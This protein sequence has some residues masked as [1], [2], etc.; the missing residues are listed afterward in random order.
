VSLG[1]AELLARLER[2]LAF[3]LRHGLDHEHGGFLTSLDHDGFVVDDDKSVWM[4]GRAAW[5]FAHAA[6]THQDRAEWR[7]AARSAAGFLLRHGF[8][9]RG[10]MPFLVTRDGRPLRRR[11][12]AYSEAFAAMGFAEVAALD[13]DA[14]LARRARELAAAFLAHR[15]DPER[16]PPKW[17]PG[18]RALSGL[19]PPMVALCLSQALRDA[20]GWDDGRAVA[21]EA[22]AR[23]RRHADA[24]RGALLELVD[25]DGAASP[26]FDGRTLNPG[27]ALEAAWFVLE[28]AAR[29]D[30]TEAAEVRA[31]GLRLAEWT[32]RR[33]WDTEH[34]G[35]LYFVSLDARPI[36]EYWQDQKFWWPQLE[37]LLAALHAHRAGGG[38]AWLERAEQAWR[39]FTDHHGDDAGDECL[40]WLD[41]AGRPVN[42]LKGSM[43]KGPFHHPRA[44]LFGARLL[45]AGGR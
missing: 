26:H 7:D 13:G 45:A 3:W 1:S 22:L 32:W 43:W 9:E 34:G 44:L 2:A 4:Q 20:G 10:R 27:H 29:R 15:D 33:G 5:M 36:Q 12:Y 30:G 37:A 19:A 24:G 25:A 18:T 39:W 8:D 11:R 41:R 28:E 35:I 14:V 31:L 40:G 42:T 6:R 16:Y 17:E 21:D 23:I 38:E